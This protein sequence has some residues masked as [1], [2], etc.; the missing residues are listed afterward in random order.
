MMTTNDHS[1]DD[2]T[3][4]ERA[5]K[6][7]KTEEDHCTNNCYVLEEWPE[8][9]SLTAKALKHI[10]N[11]LQ[12]SFSLRFKSHQGGTLSKELQ[13]AKTTLLECLIQP[14]INNNCKSL[15]DETKKLLGISDS[16][17]KGALKQVDGKSLETLNEQCI[18]GD[19][20]KR[21][22]RYDAYDLTV[23]FDWLHL[24][25]TGPF[26][27]KLPDCCSFMEPNKAKKF[28]FK[29]K[30]VQFGN[31]KTT[32]VSCQHLLL[33]GSKNDCLQEYYESDTHKE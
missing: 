11:R 28:S 33:T 16:T 5:V 19:T 21:Q 8:A 4:Q 6:I 3:P 7:Q 24:E 27:H 20:V 9:D 17:L 2:C 18:N 25:G 29:K 32:T 1:H 10:V 14:C 31:D 30:K 26:G 23:P 22:Q 13:Q 15:V 12:E